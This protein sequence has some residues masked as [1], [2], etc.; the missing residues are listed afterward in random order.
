MA[1]IKWGMIVA[2]GRGKL[3]GQVFSKNRSGA[4]IR[5]KVTPTNPQTSAQTIVRQ[6]FAVF[7]QAWSALTAT[8]IASWNGAVKD[9]ATTDVFGDIKNPTGKNLFL[10]LNQSATQAG[11]P[12]FT[13]V[14]A[15]L[16]MVEGVITSVVVNTTL[17]EINS[18]GYYEGVDARLVV[19]AT[20]PVSNGTS[21]VKNR[22]RQFYNCLSDEYTGGEAFGLYTARFGRP[23]VGQKIFFGF[24]YVLPNGQQSPVQIIQAS[25]VA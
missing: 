10:R 21:Y 20:P 13:A 16:E 4:Y 25:I 9:W 17:D 8:L 24:K 6:S 22:L 14:P 18:L 7:S 19:S 5:T 23:V 11:Y 15:K 12:S 1:K 3:G 2:D